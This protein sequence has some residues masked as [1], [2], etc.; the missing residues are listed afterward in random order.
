MLPPPG[1]HEGCRLRIRGSPSLPPETDAE[2][3]GIPEN[4]DGAP[5]T[6]KEG[7]QHCAAQ[8]FSFPEHS[9]GLGASEASVQ[10]PSPH[11]PSLQV[12]SLDHP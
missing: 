5:H 3:T 6:L 8:M 9:Q 4:R 7:A 12:S 11:T 2:C 10:V 1:E